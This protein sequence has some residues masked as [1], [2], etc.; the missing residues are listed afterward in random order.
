MML[1]QQRTT[2]HAV[3]FEVDL[4]G[5]RSKSKNSSHIQKKLEEN[6]KQAAQGP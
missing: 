6:A 3:A 1:K 2:S 5:Q 4:T